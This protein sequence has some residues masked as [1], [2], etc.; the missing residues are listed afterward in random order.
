M[1]HNRAGR[2][3]IRFERSKQPC[4]CEFRDFCL[5]YLSLLSNSCCRC[6]KSVHLVDMSSS[7]RVV[8]DVVASPPAGIASNRTA[9]V[10]VASRFACSSVPSVWRRTDDTFA[11][12]APVKVICGWSTS[13]W[14]GRTG[15]VDGACRSASSPASSVRRCESNT[16][17]VVTDIDLDTHTSGFEWLM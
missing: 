1:A 6:L 14:C 10:V 4:H 17:D 13:S 8:K 7:T 16:L 3:S 12:A 2:C 9:A 15:V 11:T 5:L